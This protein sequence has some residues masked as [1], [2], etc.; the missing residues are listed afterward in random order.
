[1]DRCDIGRRARIRNAIIGKNVR[2]PADSQIGY[3][4]DEDRKK[5]LVTDSGIVLVSGE[6]SVVEVATLSF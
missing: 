2:I 6:R 3:D 5:Y 1:M 4:M